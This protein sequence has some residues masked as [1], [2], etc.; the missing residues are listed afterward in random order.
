MGGNFLLGRIHNC[1]I[2][3]SGKS[4][5]SV[6]LNGQII[7]MVKLGFLYYSSTSSVEICDSFHCQPAQNADSWFGMC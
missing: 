3:L 5:T 1:Y 4:E 6:L 7:G 2:N